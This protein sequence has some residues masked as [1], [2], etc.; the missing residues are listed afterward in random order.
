[1]IK[2]IVEPI[3]P[4][5]AEDHELFVCVLVK[6]V[7]RMRECDECCRDMFSIFDKKI[8]LTKTAGFTF[9]FEQCQNIINLAWSLNVTDNLTGWV[10]H[11][12][13]ADL[14]NTTTGSCTAK[15]FNDLYNVNLKRDSKLVYFCNNTLGYSNFKVGC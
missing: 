12:F 14:D 3:A 7:K 6:C 2:S 15:D 10:V 1:M 4:T 13:N 5:F 11:H 9:G 8:D